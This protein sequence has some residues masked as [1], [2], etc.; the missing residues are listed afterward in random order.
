MVTE[1]RSAV[2]W[3]ERTVISPR[4]RPPVLT[5]CRNSGHRL[6]TSPCTWTPARLAQDPRPAQRTRPAWAH[7]TQGRESADPSV[8]TPARGAHLRP[9]ERL[10]PPRPLLRT[11]RC[12]DRR[13]LRSRRCD[14]RRPQPHPTRL[15][16]PS[17]G[18]P[19]KAVP[20]NSPTYATS[21]YDRLVSRHSPRSCLMGHR[22]DQ[23]GQLVTVDPFQDFVR[24]RGL[25][26][27]VVRG[28]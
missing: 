27:S 23:P 26:R 8:S 15:D 2:S 7:R 12:R 13:L 21:W 17:L 25:H 6:T 24:R 16:N 18:Q 20:L 11:P 5:T 14:H 4:C 28:C 3:P 22:E 10:P 1:C 19:P 9:A